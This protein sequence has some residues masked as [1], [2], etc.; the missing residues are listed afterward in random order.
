LVTRLLVSYS[1]SVTPSDVALPDGAE[2]IAGGA[3]FVR[4]PPVYV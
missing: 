2:V 1:N 4:F 3:T